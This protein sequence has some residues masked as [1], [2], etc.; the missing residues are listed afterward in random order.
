[1][2]HKSLFSKNDYQ[3]NDQAFSVQNQEPKYTQGALIYSSESKKNRAP[4]AILIIIIL[5]ACAVFMLVY[6]SFSAPSS[7]EIL[8]VSRGRLF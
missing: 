4:I 5:L 8:N 2:S 6:D 7:L 1:M 3:P